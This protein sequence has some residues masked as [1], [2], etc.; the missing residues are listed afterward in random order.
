MN[1]DRLITLGDYHVTISSHGAVEAVSL[2]HVSDSLVNHAT[3][4]YA[5]AH[6]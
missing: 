2:Q 5:S 4:L 1:T 6:T 3:C